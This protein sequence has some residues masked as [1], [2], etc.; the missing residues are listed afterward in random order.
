[1]D[2]DSRRKCQRSCKVRTILIWFLLFFC[3][4][5]S[6]L[7]H[8]H[9]CWNICQQKNR[10]ATK[11]WRRSSAPAMRET[12]KAVWRRT[13]QGL[14]PSG[15]SAPDLLEK[16]VPNVVQLWHHSAVMSLWR[17]TI[18]KLQWKWSVEMSTKTKHTKLCEGVL[19]ASCYA[20]GAWPFNLFSIYFRRLWCNQPY[21][22][23]S[24][25]KQQL[26]LWIS[27]VIRKQGKR[28]HFLVG[29]PLFRQ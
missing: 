9:Q 15:T 25:Q 24:Q 12:A 29:Y 14:C 4:R 1:M 20:F 28:L 3:M 10:V 22:Q 27:S 23:H 8:K 11:T 19:H 13:W 6:H 17:D 5:T 16:S 21:A 7:H 26:H 2:M 18:C